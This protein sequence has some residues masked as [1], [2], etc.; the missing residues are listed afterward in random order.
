MFW[1]SEDRLKVIGDL[2]DKNFLTEQNFRKF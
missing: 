2:L 1:K